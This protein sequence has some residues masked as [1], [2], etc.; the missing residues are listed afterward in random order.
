[1]INQAQR[2]VLTALIRWLRDDRQPITPD[3][4]RA[5]IRII[6]QDIAIV[7]PAT[8]AQQIGD[9][10][11][12]NV[13]AFAAMPQ[14]FEHAMVRGLADAIKRKPREANPYGAA[15]PFWTAW[16]DAWEIWTNG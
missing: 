12:P 15:S 9:E 10:F 4:I 16:R 2:E 14:S 7:Q 6:E 13:P 1:M 8:S 3:T 5:A 11:L